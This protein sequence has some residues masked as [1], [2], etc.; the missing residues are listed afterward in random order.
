MEI[1]MNLISNDNWWTFLYKL[2]NTL[3][4]TIS[5]QKHSFESNMWKLIILVVFSVGSGIYNKKIY[6]SLINFL[7]FYHQWTAF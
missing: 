2:G 6:G 5:D 3:P 1:S 7:F 4:N